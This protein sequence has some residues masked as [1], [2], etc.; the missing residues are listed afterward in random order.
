MLTMDSSWH[1]RR[2]FF[3]LLG[4]AT[5]F[6]GTVARGASA[7]S[8]KAAII[9]RT[10][11]GDYG[12]G[13]DTIFQGVERVSVEAIA[14]VNS[15]G[16]E[17][18]AIRSG[19]KRKYTDYREML[20]KE[21]PRLVSIAPR[22][23]DCHKEM[24][25][26]AIEVG[27]HCIIEK[28]FTEHLEDADEIVRAAKSHGVQIVV[29]H[30][31]RYSDTFARIKRLLDEGFF[32]Q[33]L[34]M[35]VQ[36]KQ[37]HRAGGEDLI[38][39][40]THDFDAMRYF[41][42]DPISCFASVMAGGKPATRSDVRKGREPVLVAGDTIRATFQFPKN[43]QCSWQSVKSDDGW[44]IAPRGTER[45]G[46]HIFGTKRI[47]A[48]YSLSESL[49]YDSPF[50]GHKSQTSEWKPLPDP[51]NWPPSS[52]QSNLARDLIHA[53]E[54]GSKPL[55]NAEDGRWTIEMLAAIYESHRSRQLVTFP[56]K[57]RSNPLFRL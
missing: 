2:H 6:A 27:A 57:E 16:L 49:Y 33:V 30:K 4:A 51:K 28:P 7:N 5:A 37:D 36:G 8:Y 46:F 1:H 20:A 54:S 43:I 53:I 45:W 39:L 10:G 40:G 29:G 24:A 35:R 26:A 42:N 47:L 38:V 18:A 55:C 41:F 44:N 50:L 31:Y 56:L 9:G 3:R 13:F 21:K 32:G 34:E 15:E 14:D 23:P 52:H 19:A 11:G 22:H 25:L 48:H 12:H 17:K